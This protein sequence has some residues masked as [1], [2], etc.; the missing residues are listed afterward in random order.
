MLIMVM[1]KIKAA[2]PLYFMFFTCSKLP[3]MPNDLLAQSNGCFPEHGGVTSS[4][5]NMT[6]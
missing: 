3:I 1:P 6:Q 4:E 2:T 5:D